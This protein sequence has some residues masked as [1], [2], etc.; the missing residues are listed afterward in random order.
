M[1]MFK[2]KEAKDDM[3]RKVRVGSPYSMILFFFS[4]RRWEL[5]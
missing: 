3:L 1:N 4:P 5:S 2:S